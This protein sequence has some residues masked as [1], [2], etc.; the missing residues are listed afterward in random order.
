MTETRTIGDGQTVPADIFET[1][2]G[3]VMNA[4][5][6][7]SVSRHT[8]V[9]DAIAIALANERYRHVPVPYPEIK[10]HE[11]SPEPKAPPITDPDMR[12]HAMF[13][14]IDPDDPDGLPCD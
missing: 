6:L 12:R 1:A 10:R 9:V 11:V 8:D 7:K 4:R 5:S 13:M 3:I 2:C 14:G